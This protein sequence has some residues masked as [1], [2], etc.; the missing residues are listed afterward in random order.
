M[1]SATPQATTAWGRIML[2]SETIKFEHS[3]FA[4]PFAAATAFLVTDGLPEWRPLVWLAVAMVG[5]RTFGMGANRVID[6][7]I[8]ARNPRTASRAIPAGLITSRQVWVYMG[9]ALAA[10]LLAVSQLDRLAWYLSPVVI[11]VLTVY[12][13]TKRFTWLAHLALGAV[14]IIIPPATWVALTG[15]LNWG[16]TWLG[17]GAMFW[18]AGFDIIYATADIEIDRAQGLNSI[19]ARFGIRAALWISRSFH[20]VTVA[21]L[22]IAGL[23]LDAHALYFAGTGAAAALLTY[24]QR[25]ISPNDLSKLGAAFF[26]MNG[27]IAVVFAVFVIAGTLVS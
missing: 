6:A 10:F 23:L 21:A 7:G 14:Y 24:E 15:D 9:V 16:V 17:I 25:L 19:P 18:V 27:I 26:T 3:V 11:A 8:D 4:L 5:A 1:A 2:F 12:P 13:Y 22:V 20:L